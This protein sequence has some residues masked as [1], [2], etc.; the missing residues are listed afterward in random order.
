MSKPGTFNSLIE[1]IHQYS[2]K[3]NYSSQILTCRFA[4]R[5][6]PLRDNDNFAG[7][8]YK[9]TNLTGFGNL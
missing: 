6:F 3:S 1:K 5:F 7:R 8:L 2:S 4:W 9:R